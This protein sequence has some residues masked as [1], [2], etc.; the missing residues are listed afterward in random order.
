MKNKVIF[1]KQAF[2]L[3]TRVDSNYLH[4][5]KIRDDGFVLSLS[6]KL[7]K[8]AQYKIIENVKRRIKIE[9][10]FENVSDYKYQQAISDA[11]RAIYNILTN[12]N[13][14]SNK[15]YLRHLAMRS[16]MLPN[17]GEFRT[18]A[19]F[20]KDIGLKKPEKLYEFIANT[21]MSDFKQRASLITDLSNKGLKQV[22]S[23][24]MTYWDC[25]YGYNPALNKALRVDYRLHIKEYKARL[26]KNLI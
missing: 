19:T 18:L 11:K 26:A 1:Y 9:L 14:E 24:Y 17:K 4:I 8:N 25:W 12:K 20:C 22:I 6:Q 13:T 16:V 10:P 15:A 23:N 7:P 3:I 2:F 21:I 5:N